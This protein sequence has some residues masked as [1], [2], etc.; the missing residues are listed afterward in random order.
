MPEAC[1]SRCATVA[2]GGPQGSSTE[3]VRS[4]V[5]TSTASA[6]QSLVNEAQGKR[7][8]GSPI[9]S[10]TS[11]RRSSYGSRRRTPAALVPTGHRAIE[12]SASMARSAYRRPA[13]T[14]CAVLVA[15][16]GGVGAARLLAGLVRVV[17]PS[18]VTAV[19]NTGDDLVLHGLH[20][21]P[22]IDTVTYTLAGVDNKE[23]GWGLAGETWTVAETSRS[24]AARAGSSSGTATWPP[25][26]SGPSG[27]PRGRAL[28]DVTAELARP[29]G[30]RSRLLPMSDDP[31]RTRV[32]LADAPHDVEAEVVVPGLLRPAAPRRAGARRSASTA[33][34]AATPAP[35]VLEAHRERRAIVCCPSNPVVSIGPILAVPGVREALVARRDRCGGGVADRGRRGAQGTGRPDAAPSSATS[36]RSSAWPASTP[37]GRHLRDRRGRPR[38]WP[39]GRGRRESG[40][41][42]APTVMSDAGPGGA[43]GQ[44][45]A[46]CPPDHRTPRPRV[47]GG[48]GR[49]RS[50]RRHGIPGS[51]G[52]TSATCSLSALTG[53]RRA[54][55]RR[56]RRGRGDPEDRVQGRGPRWCRSTPRTRPPRW[57]WSRRRRCGCCAG[58]ATSSSPRP[59][60]GS[61]APTPGSTSPTSTQGTAALLPARR[62]PLGPAHPRRPRAPARRRG[63]GDRV[64]HVR[65]DVAAGGDRRRHRVRRGRGGGRPA[66][67]PRRRRAGSWP[68]T[69]VCVADEIA[70]RRRDGDG[71]G[72]RRPGRRSCGACPPAGCGRARW[73]PRSS[74][75]PPRT[76]SA[77]GRRQGRHGH[78]PSDG[79]PAA[80]RSRRTRL[81]PEWMPS[82]ERRPGR[83]PSWI[84]ARSMSRL[85]RRSRPARGAG[86]AGGRRRPRRPW[87]GRAR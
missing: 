56:R 42:V 24:S 77:D 2:P 53:R 55:P 76:C 74:G 37:V 12:R 13:L 46:R 9:T 28:S 26:C 30:V 14:L 84:A 57:P 34:S 38:A 73:R 50:G 7:R 82:L 5:P 60:T 32:T 70:R 8:V 10:S 78:R 3:S 61:S 85:L 65:P 75:R 83:H 87:S 86:A 36:R 52:T 58:G 31:V 69:E 4:S 16:A 48:A 72:P 44:G 19:V 64:G 68:A 11:T 66:W 47:P 59:A 80:P 21:S 63:R 81:Q 25:T 51:P 41:I 49:R 71:Q 18:T 1:A 40:A 62:R 20:I 22:D 6:V 23:T 39:G 27:C 45:G 67:H 54:V 35:G 29:A 33:P 15:I 17:D 43:P 79:R